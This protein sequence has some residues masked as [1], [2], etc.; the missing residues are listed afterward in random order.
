MSGRQL[1]HA[2]GRA[3]AARGPRGWLQRW[4]RRERGSPAEAARS[5]PAAAGTADDA[6]PGQAIGIPS[7]PDADAIEPGL[8]GGD[9]ITDGSSLFHVEHTHRDRGSGTLLVEM[10]NCVTL[11]LSVWSADALAA[12]PVRCVTPVGTPELSDAPWPESRD[13]P[14]RARR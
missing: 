5:A 4:R 10:E 9:Y 7:S 12:R 14:A 13:V 8:S 1:G 2:A 11:E 6:A 3:S